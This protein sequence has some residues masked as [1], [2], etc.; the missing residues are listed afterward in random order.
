[1]CV[2]VCLFFFFCVCVRAGARMYVLIG[3]VDGG[4]CDV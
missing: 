4:E 1:M 2:C 3:D